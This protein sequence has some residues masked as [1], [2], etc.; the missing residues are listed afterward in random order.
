MSLVKIQN[1]NDGDQFGL[2]TNI[3]VSGTADSKVVSVNLYSPYG[4]TNY[5]L[6][7]EPVS[8]TNGQWFANISFNTGGEREIVAE[9]I[10]ADGHSIEF[11]PEE[12][13]LLIG[14]GLI[15]PVGVGFVVTSDFQPPH[16]P[17]HNGIDIAHKL[18]LP[19]KPI[20]ASASGKVIVAVKHCSVGDG[21]CGG[22]YGNVVYIDH[23]SMGLQTRYAHLKSVNVSAGN[24]IN[25]GDLVGIMGNTGRST[26]IHLHFEVRRNGVPLNP[27]DF[28]NPIV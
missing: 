28:V 26:G 3:S 6:I 7:S 1:P 4:G 9:G 25:Q 22:G 16:R 27:R 23:S 19:D 13:T 8:V 11:D 5:P 14:T 18:G 24:T 21:D 20:F 17:R 10:D 12:I 15:K 2:N